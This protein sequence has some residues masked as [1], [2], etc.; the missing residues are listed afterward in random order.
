[1]EIKPTTCTVV[2][3]P[4]TS[5]DLALDWL[6]EAEKPLLVTP[7]AHVRNI[8]RK[9][10]PHVDVMTIYSL[11]NGGGQAKLD[12]THYDRIAAYGNFTW[13]RNSKYARKLRAYVSTNKSRLIWFTSLVPNSPEVAFGLGMTCGLYMMSDWRKYFSKGEYG[14]PPFKPEP[15]AEFNTLCADTILDM[16]GDDVVP[17]EPARAYYVMSQHRAPFNGRYHKDDW[18]AYRKWRVIAK[19]FASRADAQDWMKAQ[20][21]DVVFGDPKR[22]QRKKASASVYLSTSIDR[23]LRTKHPSLARNIV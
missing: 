10:S 23:L 9:T 18:R 22:F 8:V 13:A 7:H 4:A 17:A 5:L 6:A 2:T 15:T 12:R 16:R 19:P 11:S 1:M 3:P 14:R 20:S 21:N